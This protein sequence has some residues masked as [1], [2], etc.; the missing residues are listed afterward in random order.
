MRTLNSDPLVEDLREVRRA[1]R[2]CAAH[3]AKHNHPA[4]PTE[5][6]EVLLPVA[7]ADKVDEDVD[8]GVLRELQHL[9]REILRLVVDA[10]GAMLLDKRDL[11][12][13]AGCRDDQGTVKG[14]RSD[15]HDSSRARVGTHAPNDLA[16]WIAARPTPDAPA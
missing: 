8:A 15:R 16:S 5:R 6:P 4:I 14:A 11:L 2:L 10:L 1:I 3:Q 7:C 9:G 12:V 13:C